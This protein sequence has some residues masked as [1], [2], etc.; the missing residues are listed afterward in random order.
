MAFTRSLQTLTSVSESGSSFLGEEGPR[1]VSAVLVSRQL[2]LLWVIIGAPKE[3]NSGR[4]STE[5]RTA[6]KYQQCSS[7]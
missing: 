6:L 3:I 1:K 4:E 7:L 5:S 2:C